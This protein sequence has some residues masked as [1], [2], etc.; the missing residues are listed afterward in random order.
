VA[1]LQSITLFSSGRTR[2]PVPRLIIQ[3][4]GLQSIRHSSYSFFFSSGRTRELVARLII[5]DPGLQ[6]IRHS[7]NPSYLE[8]VGYN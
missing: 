8:M 5:Q 7:I 2:E 6:S 4:A 1:G 3:D